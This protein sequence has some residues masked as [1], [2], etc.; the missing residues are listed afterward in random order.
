MI[1]GLDSFSHRWLE[2]L[3]S[4][5]QLPNLKRLMEEGSFSLLKTPIVGATPHNWASISTGSSFK[6]HGCTW[7]VRAPGLAKPLYG[8]SSTTLAA[9]PIWATASRVGVKSILLDVPQ[10]YPVLWENVV[11]VGEDGRPDSSYRCIQ[12]S[13]GY[14]SEDLYEEYMRRAQLAADPLPSYYK[15]LAKAHL[16]KIRVQEAKGWEGVGMGGLYEAEIP[17][18]L[19][20]MKYTATAREEPGRII[21][22][23]YLLIRPADR[24]VELYYEKRAGAK[25]GRS[26]LGSWSEW[27]RHEFTIDGDKVEA[28]FRFKLLR[29]GDAGRSLHVYFS[30]IY[31][32]EGFAHP[33]ELSEKLIEA[34]GPY[35]QTPTRQQVVLCGACDVYTFIEEL[36]YMGWWYAR[37]MRY[38]MERGEW[39]LFYIKYHA[40]DF[41]NHLCAYMIDERHPLFDSER[42]EE[43]WR[44]WSRVFEPADEMVKIALE[45]VGDEGIVAVVS[46]HCS[47]LMHPF[48]MYTTILAGRIVAEALER[49]GYI[50]RKPGGEVDWARS[51]VRPGSFGFNLAVRGRDPGGVIEPEEYEK[52]RL[53][54]IEILRELRNPVTNAHLFKLVCRRE[55]AEALGYGGPRCADV[56][57]WPNFGDHLELEYEKV[58]REDYAKMGV[59]DIGTWEWPVGIPT[60]AHEDIAM[61]IVRG[62]GVKRGYKCKKLYSLTNV[63]PTLCYAA[64]LPI[65]RDCTGGVIKEMLA[66]EE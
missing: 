22:K 12:V 15:V 3:F 42:L 57:V 23:L 24:L 13:K 64:G 54:L 6:D 31:P 46:D 7:W 56:F 52:I 58:T 37:A 49:E 25:L 29:L 43:G 8:F 33:G 60:G 36:E 51:L 10:S 66:L 65:P 5:G 62:P 14:L 53:R 11:H 38:L 20:G 17:I 45:V 19:E 30:Q 50:V 35:L 63:V 34:C 9:E 28:C 55:D 40:P 1:I 18:Y 41:L 4:R 44:L 16:V 61:L 59:P 48:Y 27:I 26:E 47:K 39:G 2:P 32:A 21:A